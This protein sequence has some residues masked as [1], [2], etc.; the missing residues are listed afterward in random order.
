MIASKF[1][2]EILLKHLKHINNKKGMKLKW[3]PCQGHN[4][5]RG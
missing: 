1:N 2:V 5:K 4:K 3:T